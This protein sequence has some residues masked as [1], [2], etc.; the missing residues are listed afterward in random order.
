MRER[1]ALVATHRNLIVEVRK[2]V[3][4]RSETQPALAPLLTLTLAVLRRHRAVG[5]WNKAHVTES[6]DLSGYYAHSINVHGAR[7]LRECVVENAACSSC[8]QAV[9]FP[10]AETK[11]AVTALRQALKI[12]DT[13]P[14]L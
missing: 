7:C 14:L 1:S 5:V 9:A 10:C 4:L 8:G 6:R 3:L 11:Q 12:F 2:A 13:D